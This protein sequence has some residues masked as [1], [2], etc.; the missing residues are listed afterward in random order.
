MLVVA[1]HWRESMRLTSA[2]MT[3]IERLGQ[4]RFDLGTGGC[5][6][7]Y[8]RF[9]VEEGRPGDVI[10][11]VGMGVLSLSPE[12]AV[13]VAGS[14]LD[15]GANLKPPRFRVLRNSNTPVRCPC[16]RSFGLPYPGRPGPEC[17]AYQPILASL[18]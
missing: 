3:E 1:H 2:A 11:R 17:R 14:L 7:I 6:G 8:Y 12:A 16:G 13:V 15:W 18:R 4:V 10:V 9:A 5:C